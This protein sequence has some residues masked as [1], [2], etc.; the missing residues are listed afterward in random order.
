MPAGSKMDSPMAKAEPISNGGGTSAVLL[1]PMEVHGGA[2]IHLQPVE[3]P[4]WMP[5]GGCAVGGIHIGE[6]H[7]RLSPMGG[8]PR[9]SRG[10]V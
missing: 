1:Q 8:T 9:W 10:R 7:G 2:E 4:R 5:K 6:F 3:D